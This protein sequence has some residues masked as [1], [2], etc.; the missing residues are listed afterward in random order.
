MATLPLTSRS[1]AANLGTPLMLVSFAMVAGFVFWLRANA[2]PTAVVVTEP[3]EVTSGSVVSMAAFSGDTKAFM[4]REIELR[5]IPVASALGPHSFWTTLIDANDTPYLVHL[6]SDL[7][8]AGTTANPGSLVDIVG[9]VTTMSDSILTDWEA[10]GSFPGPAD[11]I[12]AEFAED[13]LEITSFDEVVPAP[14]PAS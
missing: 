8:G 4:D 11:R 2:E 9:T 12:Q 5:D 13:F 7:A 6:S 10:A 14:P 1:G 3:D